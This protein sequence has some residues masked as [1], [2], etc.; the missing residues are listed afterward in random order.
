M[1]RASLARPTGG[2]NV[3]IR[4]HRWLAAG[5]IA[6]ALTIAAAAPASAMDCFIASRS[7]QG[8][9]QAGTNSNAWTIV[10]LSDFLAGS[11]SQACINGAV[12]AVAAAGLPTQ[13]T[14]KANMVIGET[15]SNPNLGNGKGLEHLDES[16][17][18][19]AVLGVVTAYYTAHNCHP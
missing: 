16:P 14:T 4:G 18:T 15:S 8:N 10:T 2:G 5:A 11:A 1:R 6:G 3:K 12:A 13:F 9:T 19:G 17:I 7:T